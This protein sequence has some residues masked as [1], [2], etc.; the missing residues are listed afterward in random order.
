MINISKEELSQ[1]LEIDDRIHNRVSELIKLHPNLK[2]YEK[3]FSTIT[4][5]REYEDIEDKESKLM[6]AIFWEQHWRYQGYASG[7]YYFPLKCLYDDNWINEVIEQHNIKTEQDKQKAEDKRKLELIHK[8]EQE[9][10]LLK[11][12]Q[13]KYNQ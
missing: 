8:E 5:E 6:I 10:K 9:R 7:T 13:E 12:L 2:D 4:L 11:D 3:N 1:Y